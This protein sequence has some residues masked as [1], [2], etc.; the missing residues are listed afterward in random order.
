MNEVNAL[1]EDIISKLKAGRRPIIQLEK[2]IIDQIKSA[3]LNPQGTET[4][5][6]LCLMGHSRAAIPELAPLLIELL[7]PTTPKEI[8]IFT[9]EVTHKHIIADHFRQGIKL[10]QSYLTALKNLFETNDWELREWLLRTVEASG[11]S[12]KYFRAEIESIKPN[13][14]SVFNVHARY[15]VEIMQL[16]ESRLK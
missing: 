2:E 8:L 6:A 11:S 12:A 10:P 1:Y 15:C 7:K 16:L 9:L 3:I 13:L 5:K 4:K 14:L